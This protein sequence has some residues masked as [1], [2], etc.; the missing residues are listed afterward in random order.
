MPQNPFVPEVADDD[1]DIGTVD[2]KEALGLPDALPP[3]RLPSTAELAAQARSAPLP[4]RLAALAAWAGEEGR[5]VTDDGDLTPEDSADAARA[6]GVKPGDLAYLW[7]YALAVEW[8]AYDGDDDERVVPGETADDWAG[9][10]ETVCDAWAATLAAVLGETLLIT[11]PADDEDWD[12]LGLGDIDFVGQATALTVL[13]FLARREGLTVAE[14]TEVLW[15]NTCGDMPAAQA[16]TVRATWEEHFGDPAL[17]LLSELGDLRAVTQ[18]GGMVRLTPL[19]LAALREQLV[20]AGV[21]IPLLPATAAELTA[22]QL[23]AMA[24]GVSD[25][26]FEAEA[27]AWIAARGADA[28]ARELLGL[29]AD[30][31][32][33]ERM[34]A[35]AA[36]TRIGPAAEPGWRDSLDVPEVR[37]YAKM[38]LTGPVEDVADLPPDLEPL[39][40]DLAWVATDM[41]TLACDEDYPDPDEIAAAFREAVPAGQEAML[42]DA[43][44]R[45]THPDVVDVLNHVGKYHPDKQVAKAARAA[46]HRAVSRRGSHS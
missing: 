25:E 13:L 10:D 12:R 34:L 19:A 26:E 37:A 30:G 28:A 6:L 8:L 39:P 43:M 42:F 7:E 11:G 5:E 33:G 45:G 32:P 29:A 31:S 9:T 2:I 15:E 41:L 3:I 27:D 20:E 17:L 23:L 35:V 46:A 24:E 14:F 22:A 16:A 21:E 38:A 36:V 40:E 4:G 44:G 18:A 1:P